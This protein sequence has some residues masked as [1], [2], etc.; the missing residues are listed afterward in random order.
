MSTKVFNILVKINLV[1]NKCNNTDILIMH[2]YYLVCD[3]K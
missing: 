1:T 2:I 3:I